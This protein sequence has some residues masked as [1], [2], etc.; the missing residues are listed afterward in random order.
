MY[1]PRLNSGYQE[2]S[3]TYIRQLLPPAAFWETLG[4]KNLLWA[5]G[6]VRSERCLQRCSLY[7]LSLQSLTL[8]VLHFKLYISL[9]VVALTS[10]GMPASFVSYEYHRVN[11][12][13]LCMTH[14]WLSLFRL[15]W[16]CERHTQNGPFWPMLISLH[17]LMMLTR[18]HNCHATVPGPS[19]G[20]K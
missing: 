12:W 5:G 20:S 16:V 10:C 15:H 7:I 11:D 18:T 2:V 14:T 3:L 19:I 4:S 6:L 8:A 17:A 13:A 9:S 1:V